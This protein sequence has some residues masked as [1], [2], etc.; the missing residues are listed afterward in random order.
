MEGYHGLTLERQEPSTRGKGTHGRAY[1]LSLRQAGVSGTE[2][3][4]LRELGKTRRRR[5]PSTNLA[6]NLPKVIVEDVLVLVLE[7]PPL[8]RRKR[9]RHG[10][11]VR[12]TSTL[13]RLLQPRG[14]H[15]A[16][17]VALRSIER[18]YRHLSIPLVRIR[19]GRRYRF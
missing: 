8:V 5:P 16:R 19:Q 4:V 2:G 14:E 7:E 17:K 18:V 3:E 6:A 12:G 11:E 13:T 10:R 15:T 1:P 9:L